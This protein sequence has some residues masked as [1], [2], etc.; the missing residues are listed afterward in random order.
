MEERKGVKAKEGPTHRLSG[1]ADL[2]SDGLKRRQLGL[3]LEDLDLLRLERD[4][5]LGGWIKTRRERTKSQM[6]SSRMVKRE[7]DEGGADERGRIRVR[8]RVTAPEHPPQ[9][10]T[11]SY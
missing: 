10:M 1:L 5:E 11:T 7:G 4:V 6:V 3:A 2:L 9:V 8:A